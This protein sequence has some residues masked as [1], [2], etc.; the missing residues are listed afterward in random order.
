MDPAVKSWLCEEV[1]RFD[2][3]APV[4][5]AWMPPSSW[6]TEASFL[7]LETDSVFAH[8]WQPIARLDQLKDPG[9]Y[10][11]GCLFGEPWVLLRNQSGELRGF[12]N[13]CRHK[14]R[15]VVQGC[16]RADELVCGYHAWTYDLE[17]G[18]KRAPRI[19]GIREFDR[20]KTSLPPLRIETWG[21]WVFANLSGEAAP[22]RPGLSEL[23]RRLGASGW[24]DL[25]FVGRTTWDIG[26]NWKV[27]ADNYLDGGYHIPH[28]HPT[29]DAQIDMKTY[30]T[31]VFDSY[32]IQTAE[33]SSQTDDRIDYDSDARIGAGAIYAWLYPNFTMNRYGPC[34]DTNWIIPKGPDRC[35]VVYEF[36]F[37]RTEGEDAQRFIDESTE[38]S[39]VTQRE[40]ISICES[41]QVGLSSRSYDRGRYAPQV[42]VGEYH[43]HQLLAGDL[44]R[45][46]RL[47]EPVAT[48]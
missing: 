35:Q 25:C 10:V 17:G 28:M 37:A 40:D 4:E 15:E 16:G 27:Y 32:S 3:Q 22:L 7:Q 19:A 39:A 46:L 31:E 2:H 9:Q 42:E 38:Q 8:S 14:G 33:P 41:V 48:R 18:L 29:L 36:F 13:S 34:L 1:S 44:R 20:A 11:T 24:D 30:K 12:F 43:F 45:A 47:D 5:E 26:C 21:P 23:D 6:Y